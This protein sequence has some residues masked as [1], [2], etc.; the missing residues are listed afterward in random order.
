[1]SDFRLYTP[2]DPGVKARTLTA[3]HFACQPNSQN[4]L[5]DISGV[6]YA[7]GG[8]GT[9]GRIPWKRARCYWSSL[10]WS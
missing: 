9:K 5:P 8:L 1:M 10:A 6:G 3:R 2:H 7:K 4:A